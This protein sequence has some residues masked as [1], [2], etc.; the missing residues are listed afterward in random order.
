MT[1]PYFK[2][3]NPFEVL[4]CLIFCSAYLKHPHNTAIKKSLKQRL[5]CDAFRANIP[6]LLPP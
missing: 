1:S 5:S 3:N 6:A 4:L 2:S